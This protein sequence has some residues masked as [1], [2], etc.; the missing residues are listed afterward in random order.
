[1]DV[2]KTEAGILARRFGFKTGPVLKWFKAEGIPSILALK[3]RYPGAEHSEAMRQAR[4]EIERF[5][6]R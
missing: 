2:Q 1:M 5:A 6:F 4:D 3:D